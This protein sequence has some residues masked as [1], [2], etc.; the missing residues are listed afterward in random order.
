MDK[1]GPAMGNSILSILYSRLQDPE[2]ALELYLKGYI[3]NELPPF[4]VLAETAGGGNPYFTTGAGGML[5]AVIFGFG[6]LQITDDGIIQEKNSPSNGIK[7]IEFIGLG[8]MKKNPKSIKVNVRRCQ[9]HLY[10][11]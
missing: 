4:G 10:R 7:S 8:L 3:P 5:Q 11:R 6:G 9:Y 1:N 2:K